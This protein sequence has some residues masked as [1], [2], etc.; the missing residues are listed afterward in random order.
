[1]SADAKRCRGGPLSPLL[2][3]IYLDELDKELKQRGLSFCRYA[4]V[5]LIGRGTA[6]SLALGSPMMDALNHRKVKSFA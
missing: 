3:N 5:G 1:M 4:E 2:A 6:S